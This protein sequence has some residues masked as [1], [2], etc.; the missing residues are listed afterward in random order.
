[1]TYPGDRVDTQFGPNPMGER[2]E[3]KPV[4]CKLCGVEVCPRCG[5][6]HFDTPEMI[7]LDKWHRDKT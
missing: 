2:P 3:K 7:C 4:F 5:N 1:M 6:V